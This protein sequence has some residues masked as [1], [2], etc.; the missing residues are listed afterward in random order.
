LLISTTAL[1]R[2]QDLIQNR[3]DAKARLD[4]LV[5]KGERDDH[6]AV[7]Q[8]R[9]EYAKFSDQ[10]EH[11]Q[12][13][14]KTRSARFNALAGLLRNVEA[15]L[16][17]AADITPFDAD[18]IEPTGELPPLA[19][20]RMRQRR[21]ELLA[22]LREVETAPLPSALLKEG[23]RQ[24]IEKLAERGRVNFHRMIDTGNP[25]LQFPKLS[26]AVE[27][28][29]F[30]PGVEGTPWIV[31]Q[32]HVPV[33]DANAFTVWLH[34]DAVL[35]KAM[36]EID[37]AANDA[38]A[39]SPEEQAARVADIEA[40]ILATERVEEAFTELAGGEVVRRADLNPRAFLSIQ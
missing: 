10:L 25:A 38:E 4:M 28:R 39:L 34:K 5:S 22:D 20:E 36:A 24:E 27:I 8:A 21:R 2:Q 11:L 17:S 14:Q 26:T 23:V 12:A 31:A 32:G 3:M 19:V 16:K 40:E 33:P 15:F 18:P 9:S 7:I 37:A 29:G 13:L 30:V 6:N 1:D 35:K